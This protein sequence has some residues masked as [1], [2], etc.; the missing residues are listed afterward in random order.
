MWVQ[1]EKGNGAIWLRIV[2]KK[3]M[4]QHVVADMA[5]FANDI[6]AT[7]HAA[8]YGILFDTGKADI[9]PDSAPVLEEIA[10]LLKADP[11]LKL[12]VVGH[13][14]NEG[15]IDGNMKLSAARAQ[16][17]VR[18]LTSQHGIAAARLTAFGCG[19][20]APVASNSTPDGRAKNRRVELVKQ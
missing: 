20:Y 9:K 19:Q 12:H 7:G 8:V 17:V 18:A 10:K 2:E 15:T 4:E 16:A 11:A 5:A 13:T 6:N 1:A 14:D 3:A